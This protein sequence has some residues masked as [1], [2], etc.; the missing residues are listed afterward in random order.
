MKITPEGYGALTHEM[1]ELARETAGGRLL[2]A[3]E[4]GYH[5][6][7]LTESVDRSLRVLEEGSAPAEWLNPAPLREDAIEMVINKVVQVQRARWESL[8]SGA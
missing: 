2:L 3:L 5:I 6:A 8:A 1:L 4:G 7:G